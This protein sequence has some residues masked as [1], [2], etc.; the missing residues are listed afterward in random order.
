[1]LCSAT[2]DRQFMVESSDKTWSTGEGVGKPLQYS[3]LENPM[4]SMKR[5]KSM[6]LKDELP[7]LVGAQYATGKEW[8]NNSRNNEEMEP[9]Q[10]QC[11]VVDITGDESEV[12]C[13]KEMNLEC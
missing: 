6:T 1:M 9:K 10:K 13:C 2:Q 7:R 8:R 12:R 5:Q 3:C 4:N 11:P